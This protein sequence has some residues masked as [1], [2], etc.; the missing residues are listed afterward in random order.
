LLITR[1]S[2]L[3]PRLRMSTAPG[4]I[5]R[6]G[7]ISRTIFIISLIIVGAASGATGYFINGLT[8]PAAPTITLNGAGST[9]VNPVISAINANYSRINNNIQINYQ[10]VGSGAGITDLSH[11]TVDF[12]ASDAPLNSGQISGLPGPALTIPDTIGAVAIAY[13][14]PIN[15]T[16]SVHKGLHLNVTIAAEIF[17]GSS[18]GG[19][20]GPLYWDDPAILALNPSGSLGTGVVL[21]HQPITVVHRFDSSGTTFVFTGWL[22]TSPVWK[23]G[24][25][26]SLGSSGWANGALSSP[27]NQGVASTIQTVTFTIGYVELNYALSATPPM[28]YAFVQNPNGGSSYIE[29]TLSSSALAASS[30]PNLPTGDGNWTSVNLLNQNVAGAYPIVTFS[31]IMV[32]RELNVYGSAMTQ[33]RAQALVNY[34]WFV[35]HDGQNQAKILSFVALTAPVVANAEATIR[36]IT[37]NGSTLHS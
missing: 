21:P 20:T 19:G 33:A 32:F 14:I 28:S 11:Q 12:G 13:N 15:S 18:T 7:G 17:Q 6:R 8:H 5:V 22:N 23:G 4:A 9:F 35:V 10:A 27:G 25:T 26:K 29:P 3:P 37:Y 36:L 16:Y 31:Y 2:S 30:L 24:Q 1:D 34:L